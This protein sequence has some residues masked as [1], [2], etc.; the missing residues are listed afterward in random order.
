MMV[1]I[2]QRILLFMLL[3]AF[4][5]SKPEDQ[6]MIESLEQAREAFL[7]ND[8]IEITYVDEHIAFYLP[9][10]LNIVDQDENNLIL[11]GNDYT[12]VLFINY[13]EAPNSERMYEL[14]NTDDALLY[15][16]MENEGQFAYQRIRKIESE[17]FY[18]LQI[19]I[20]GVKMTTIVSARDLVKES[21]LLMKIVRSIIEANF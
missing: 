12:Y 9:E 7:A 14:A 5:C 4:G 18:E 15:E 6:Y 17:D 11:E 19:G 2:L 1:K 10:S 20:G 13:L 3:V 16:S 21:E 8:S